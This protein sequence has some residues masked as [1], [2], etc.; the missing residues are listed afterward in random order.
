MEISHF[1]CLTVW[2]S[3][4]IGRYKSKVRSEL[5]RLWY[6]SWHIRLNV[7]CQIRRTAVDVKRVVCSKLSIY[8]RVGITETIPFV[9][10]LLVSRYRP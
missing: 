4:S 9:G 5:W 10:G 7:S 1:V 3:S 8:L 2:S 6:G